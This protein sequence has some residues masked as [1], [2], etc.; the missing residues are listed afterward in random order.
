MSQVKV[1]DRWLAYALP[2]GAELKRSGAATDLDRGRLDGDGGRGDT[3]RGRPAGSP[4]GRRSGNP[5]E[6]R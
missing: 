4:A 2:Y 5:V 3:Y 6:L 1:G